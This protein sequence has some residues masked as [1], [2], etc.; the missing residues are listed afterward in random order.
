MTRL[1]R[2][3]KELQK[4]ANSMEIVYEII[5]EENNNKDDR[6][7]DIMTD[8]IKLFN[9]KLTSAVNWMKHKVETLIILHSQGR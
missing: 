2:M 5:N 6:E 9:V 3:K 8:S 7:K 4:I 1:K